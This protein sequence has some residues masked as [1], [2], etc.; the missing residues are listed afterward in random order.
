M[1]CAGDSASGVSVRGVGGSASGALVRAVGISVVDGVTGTRGSSTDSG[2]SRRSAPAPGPMSPISS[3]SW[4]TRMS[5]RNAVSPTS[6]HTAVH[7]EAVAVLPDDL[8]GAVCGAGLLGEE[9]GEAGG[10]RAADGDAG[11]QPGAGEVS[12]VLV[13][14]ESALLQGDDPV[15]A[16]GGLLGLGGGEQDRAALGRVCAQHAVQPTAFAR[17]EFVRGFV[18]HE[19]VRVGQ[20]STG[21]TEA[22]VHAARET[23]ETFVAQA[24]EADHFEDF[25]GTPGRN[26][27]RRT[28][29]GD[30][31][32]PI[33]PDDPAHRP[34][35]RRPRVTGGRCGAGGGP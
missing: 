30:G 3:A 18:Q 11:A 25:V 29:S 28:A 2:P 7:G 19:C 16:A 15:G 24:D 23:A 22:A 31:R 14:D 32:A 26:A 20:Q 34:G 1:R 17:G 4:C 10:V 12:G 21:E 5:C 13:G 8:D 35:G 33:G 9:G 6:A 27:R